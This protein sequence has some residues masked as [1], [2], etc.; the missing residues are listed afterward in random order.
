M[1]LEPGQVLDGKYRIKRLIGEGGMGA[2]FEGENV[3]IQRRVAIKVVHAAY[4]SNSGVMARFQREA[5]AAGRIGN[6]HIL[7]VLDLGELPDGSH[8]M[9][10]EFLDGEPLSKRIET[11]GRM[12]PRELAPLAIQMLKGLGAAHGAG[13]IHRDLKPD[14]I[15]LLKEKAGVQ[16]FVKII[17]FGISK[18][19]P[20]SGGDGMKMTSTGAVMGTPYYMSP[21][22]ASGNNQIDAR[23]D[24]YAV[25]VILYEAVTGRVPFDGDT[26]NQLMFKIVLQDAPPPMEVV[27]DLDP[28]FASIVMKAMVRDVAGRFQTADEFSQALKAWLEKGAD[29]HVPVATRGD[30]SIP[31]VPVGAFG[32]TGQNPSLTQGGGSRT[33]GAVQPRATGGTWAASQPGVP[34]QP[35]GSQKLVVGAIAG[36]LALLAAIVGGVVMFRGKSAEQPPGPPTPAAVAPP[37]PSPPPAPKPVE[38]APAPRPV[39]AAPA[40]KPA[41]TAAVPAPKPAPKTASH[42][43]AAAK[44]GKPAAKPGAAAA[45]PASGAEPYFGY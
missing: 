40:P 13:I 32:K 6:D 7:E 16:D 4:A 20:L 45:K 38:V 12:D 5:Q 42:A 28:A 1:S 35:P 24:L 17:D 30:A 39:E 8:Y 43:P 34:P 25:G 9:V 18:F 2:V 11:R 26:F 41:E 14:N 36:G 37:A 3:K 31:G 22:Q 21:E 15:F 44:P 19:Q 33:G 27:P 23:S 29:V 10:L